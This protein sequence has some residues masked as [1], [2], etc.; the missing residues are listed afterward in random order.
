[1][2]ISRC[3]LLD[4]M[5]WGRKEVNWSCCSQRNNTNKGPLMMT[6]GH[7]RNTSCWIYPHAF[8]HMQ[9]Q[10]SMSE[11][12][13]KVLNLPHCDT[14][15]KHHCTEWSTLS[16]HRE[17]CFGGPRKASGLQQGLHTVEEQKE[18]KGLKGVELWNQSTLH[19]WQWRWTQFNPFN[20]LYLFPV[21]IHRGYI[22]VT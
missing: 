15:Q 9:Q 6:I 7:L 8:Q 14:E 20:I 3:T 1:M 12:S 2:I 4:K 17:I 10:V 5:G 11:I 22:A 18:M 16:W 21:L 19:S 13:V